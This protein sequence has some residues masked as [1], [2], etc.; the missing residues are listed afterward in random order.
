MSFFVVLSVPDFSAIIVILVQ[1]IQMDAR[2]HLSLLSQRPRTSLSL[3]SEASRRMLVFLA[4][5]S[6]L[7]SAGS[8]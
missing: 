8:D 6:S 2:E 3:K 1:D 7:I 4:S 5:I